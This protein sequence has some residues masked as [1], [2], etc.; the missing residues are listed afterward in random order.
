METWVTLEAT[1]TILLC[2]QV[3]YIVLS[4]IS[5]QALALRPLQAPP[6]TTSFL[7]G[8]TSFLSGTYEVPPLRASASI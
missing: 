3:V 2:S 5:G 6:E 8:T 7:S 1:M 4:L